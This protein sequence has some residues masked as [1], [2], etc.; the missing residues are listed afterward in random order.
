MTLSISKQEAF[1][2]ESS[3][4]A[5]RR[6]T[7]TA[8]ILSLEP[9]EMR[10]L[11]YPAAGRLKDWSPT[12]ID[13]EVRFCRESIK[14]L[15]SFDKGLTEDETLDRA[16]LLAHLRYLDYFYGQYHG[17]LGNLQISVFPWDA[18]QYEMQQYETGPKDALSTHDHF[19]AIEGI[20]RG[21]PSYL[22][23]QEL[24]LI[25]GL[26][27]RSPDREIL[28]RIIERI[29]SP[30]EESTI[31]GG[32]RYLSK[33]L[34]SITTIEPLQK[35]AIRFHLERA[36]TAYL[37]H[38][39]CLERELL[40]SA[41]ETWALGKEE[42]K[43]RL[44]LVYDYE[45][46]LDEL[47]QSAEEELRRLKKEMDVLA[48]KLRPDLSESDTLLFVR[49]K[50]AS[51]SDELL[52]AY[53]AIQSEIDSNLTSGLGLPA[54]AAAY[55][56][57]PPGVPVSPATNWPAPLLSEGNAIVLVDTSTDGL[58]DNSFVDL[59]WIAAHE[60]SP[61]HAA[62]SRFFQE[63]F[64]LGTTALCRFLGVP[65]EIGYVRGDWYANDEHR[66]MGFL[67]RTASP[68]VDA[69]FA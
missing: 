39:K 37:S 16:V 52:N 19:T 55:Q 23:Q 36:D 53:R 13:E 27:L 33:R 20:L 28:Q 45:G 18:I 14:G 41:H 1:S 59:P 7:I 51:T 60:G 22:K 47:V 21:V 30:T 5:V 62:Q 24:N 38:V 43:R 31:R 32:L 46:S 25:A 9:E 49:E 61:G 44:D 54:G 40:P 68:S 2:M 58:R 57:A 10:M 35:D 64:R 3:Q 26:K 8:G 56:A 50:R 48:H 29:E 12:A 63:N 4:F 65:D 34:T 66:G 6:D 42:Y 11:G 15:D 69:A 17:E 67:Y